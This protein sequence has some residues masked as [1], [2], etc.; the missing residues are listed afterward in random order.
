MDMYRQKNFFDKW[1]TK[2]NN[3]GRVTFRGMRFGSQGSTNL[4]RYNPRFIKQN[5]VVQSS[6]RVR[7]RYESI[8]LR[9]VNESPVPTLRINS[10]R[11]N[12]PGIDAGLND[13]NVDRQQ[14]R[15]RSASP[16]VIPK[17]DSS[18]QT[19]DDL[20]ESFY[21]LRKR[22]VPKPSSSNSSRTTE[23][24]KSSSKNQA[25]A[26]RG[27]SGKSSSRTT[28]NNNVYPTRGVEADELDSLQVH[29][30]PGS[31]QAHDRHPLLKQDEAMY[32][33]SSDEGSYSNREDSITG[34]DDFF[35]DSFIDPKDL[36]RLG[37][38]QAQA[39]E[40]SG[41]LVLRPADIGAHKSGSRESLKRHQDVPVPSVSKGPAQVPRTGQS[42]S[43]LIIPNR[44]I[45]KGS[46]DPAQPHSSASTSDIPPHM[47]FPKRRSDITSS[48]A[49]EGSD[50]I[51]LGDLSDTGMKLLEEEANSV[52]QFQEYMRTKGIKLDLNDVQSSEV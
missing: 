30:P 6:P 46:K 39:Q 10:N 42:K 25:T 24:S 37:P 14:R 44:F 16:K 36:E 7:G 9:D 5:Y 49:S 28:N 41:K 17:Q 3:K 34:L 40:H 51:S 4:Y 50:T 38:R 48:T 29:E 27:S 21:E 19:D 11:K 18:C 2:S 33:S 47:N 32:D 8:P 52:E 15:S 26:S 1:R 20:I 13:L 43:D 22:N 35:Y 45:D 23:E 31:S 12:I